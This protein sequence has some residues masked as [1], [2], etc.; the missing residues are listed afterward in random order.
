MYPDGRGRKV[1]TR[2]IEWS[3]RLPVNIKRVQVS[4]YFFSAHISQSLADDLVYKRRIAGG[5]ECAALLVY[6]EDLCT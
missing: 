1:R 5:S 2:L 3:L 4:L 6:V